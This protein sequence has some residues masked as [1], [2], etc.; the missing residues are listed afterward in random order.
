MGIHL[1]FEKT[2]I[3]VYESNGH[4]HLMMKNRCKVNQFQ[5]SFRS[6]MLLIVELY[7]SLENN[8]IFFSPIYIFYIVGYSLKK[9]IWLLGHTKLRAS[10]HAII[11]KSLTFSKVTRFVGSTLSF[12]LPL[13]RI[14]FDEWQVVVR[15]ID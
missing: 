10:L 9:H 2:F 1:F 14:E 7:Q 8:F 4:Q 5:K 6:E 3:H 13:C 12:V 15:V 11:P